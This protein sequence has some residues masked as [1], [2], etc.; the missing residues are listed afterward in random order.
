M[1]IRKKK[2]LLRPSLSFAQH[3]FSLKSFVICCSFVLFLLLLSR[4][5]GGGSGSFRPTRVSMVNISV[6]SSSS[7][8]INNS[9]QERLAAQH[10]SA[11][12]T[13][14]N[15]HSNGYFR[16]ESRVLFTDHVL[17]MLSANGQSPSNLLRLGGTIDCVYQR[18][19]D[20]EAERGEK[21][22]ETLTRPMLSTDEYGE[23]GTQWIV[24][25]PYP[26]ANYSAG[27]GLRAH[28]DDVGA[29]DWEL[30]AR[31]NQTVESWDMVAYEATWDREDTAV[32]F[33]K[34][35]NLR[36]DKESFPNPFTCRF[37]LENKTAGLPLTS[38]AITASQEIIR[39][40]LPLVLKTNLR[41]NESI[42]VSVERR[43]QEIPTIAKLRPMTSNGNKSGYKYELCACTMV[44][45]QAA[46]IREWIMYHA[47]LGVQRWFLYDNNSEDGL[48]DVI[49]EL[50]S[51][52][53]NV[54][55]HVWPWVKAQEAGFSHCVLKARNE[56]SWVAFFDV[57]EFYYFQSPKGRNVGLNLGY[58]GPNS[59]QA[60]LRNVLSSSPSVGEVRTD[61]YSYGPSGLK[62]S[63][64]KG[65]T[66]GY[67]CRI[68]SP[69]RHKPIV[70]PD[71]VSD[72]LL[73]Q[74]H[75]FRLKKEF[76]KKNLLPSIAVINHYKY[77]VWD[78]FKA[79]FHRRVSTYVADWQEKQNENSRDR[80][81]GLGTEAIEP[82]D[83]H[84][85]FCEV[86]DTKL[87]DFILANLTDPTTGLLPWERSG[88]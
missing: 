68:R 14:T 42:Q 9:I 26:P 38:K 29:S 2:R 5:F 19:D 63:P 39:C 77:Q 3:H 87:R 10:S 47:W 64:P 36:S 13:P 37:E 21:K 59:L 71:A 76:K 70:R 49:N 72:S 6:F 50:N 83:W 74:V 20:G 56:C 33:V 75:H 1:D 60:L 7:N 4:D 82:P 57:D 16:I 30:S 52:N 18:W 28:L 48:K 65:V 51:A 43:G 25:C 61:C 54:T 45:N 34:G 73:N 55:R 84:Q 62:E 69:E 31:E 67:T 44:W 23:T 85:R 81:P 86:W 22:E 15:T 8:S 58:P 27:V 12:S 24:R 53:Y 17:V 40:P 32:V 88:Q 78:V 79:K 41:N 46:F 66:I 80:A 35:F 11:N